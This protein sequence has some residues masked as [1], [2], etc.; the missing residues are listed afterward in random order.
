MADNVL[1][2]IALFSMSTLL[3]KNLVKQKLSRRTEYL[4][5][6]ADLN[7][8]HLPVADQNAILRRNELGA[9]W[10]V[11]TTFPWISILTSLYPPCGLKSV[12]PMVTL[13]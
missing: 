2:A 11:H 13:C 12:V 6:L 4:G 1:T 8:Q 10:V 9:Y 5:R 3:K 7:S